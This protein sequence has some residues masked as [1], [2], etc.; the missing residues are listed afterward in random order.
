MLFRSNTDLDT[1]ADSTALVAIALRAVRGT[2][3][4][5]GMARLADF[6]VGCD[7]DPI[8]RGGVAFSAAPDGTLLPDGTTT[9]AATIAFSGAL[10]PARTDGLVPFPT[11]PCAPPSPPATGTTTTTT[12]VAP[13]TSVPTLPRTGSG[14]GLPLVGGFSVVVG[15]ALLSRARRR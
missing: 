13:T 11:D 7:G 4:G 3:D 6:Q 1:D 2:T 8:D 14:T 9:V 15:L 5:P 10:L 12:M